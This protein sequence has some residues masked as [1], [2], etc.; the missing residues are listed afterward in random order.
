M[1]DV[2]TAL[3]NIVC[4][5]WLSF[6]AAVGPFCSAGGVNHVYAK[7]GRPTN[8]RTAHDP[9]D[10]Q[11]METRGRSEDETICFELLFEDHRRAPRLSG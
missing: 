7:A 8:C 5:A 10:A 1:T 4:W 9:A 11:E 3:T 6:I 2:N